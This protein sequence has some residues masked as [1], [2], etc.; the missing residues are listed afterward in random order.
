MINPYLENDGSENA[1]QSTRGYSAGKYRSN[2]LQRGPQKWV[3]LLIYFV[4][5][6][7]SAVNTGHI[8]FV[9][10]YGQSAQL[11]AAEL[12][13][14]LLGL[15]LFCVGVAHGLKSGCSG[16]PLALFV[17]ISGMGL[18][19]IIATANVSGAYAQ[20]Q[21]AEMVIRY[22]KDH[23]EKWPSDWGELKPYFDEN[24]GR[25]YHL[26]FQQL[27]E[28]VIVNFDVN[29]TELKQTIGASSKPTV[30]LIQGRSYWSWQLAVGPEEKL[31]RY[32]ESLP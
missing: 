18:G 21:V 30:H 12:M 1:L 10:S 14:N 19:S 7:W 28:L 11:D 20:D 16:I 2:W 6:G 17:S 9:Q 15:L 8:I 26:N 22:L 32:F 25:A 29:L 13:L 3:A 5:G 23:P 24:K 4:I 31:R 27:A